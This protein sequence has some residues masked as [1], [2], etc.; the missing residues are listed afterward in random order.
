MKCDTIL[1][2]DNYDSFTYNLEH[3]LALE[4]GPVP[5]VIQYH[6]LG[7]EDLSQF[8]LI[9]ISPGPGTPSEYPDYRLLKSISRP[10]VGVCLGMQI[11][12]ELYGGTTA[13]SEKCVH[14]KTD[15]IEFDGR[16]FEVAR[17][18]SL[19]ADYIPD[20]FNVLSRTIDRI[21]MAI[22]HRS[23]PLIGYQFHPESFMTQ[24]GAYFIE[25][26]MRSFTAV[27]I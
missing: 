17:Y 9:V 4:L 12:N 13:T 7:R 5:R 2:V 18:H 22:R 26:A 25:Y 10:V 21:P 23:L 11:L 6:G 27:G 24:E 16:R 8:D 19:H 3:L 15:I 20:C 1:L 14:G